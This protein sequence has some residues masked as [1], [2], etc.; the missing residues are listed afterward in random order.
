MVEIWREEEAAVLKTRSCISKRVLLGWN[1]DNGIRKIQTGSQLDND[2]HYVHAMSRARGSRIQPRD[3]VL[4]IT[5]KYDMKSMPFITPPR[6]GLED[7]IDL[8]ELDITKTAWNSGSKPSRTE[9]PPEALSA[10][11]IGVNFH[12]GP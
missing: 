12:Q 11:G 4:V 9:D 5:I 6:N 7:G 1:P 3:D 10:A 2:P 8:L